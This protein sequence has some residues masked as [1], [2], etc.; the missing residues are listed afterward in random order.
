MIHLTSPRIIFKVTLKCPILS[1][2]LSN[3]QEKS[4]LRIGLNSERKHHTDLILFANLAIDILF[5]QRK[6]FTLNSTLS[7]FPLGFNVKV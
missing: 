1:K 4:Y 5:S 7:L 2:P 3:Y 6:G